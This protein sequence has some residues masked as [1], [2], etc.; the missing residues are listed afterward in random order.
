LKKIT[1]LAV[2][3]C[4]WGVFYSCQYS[5]LRYDYCIQIC[6]SLNILGLAL[7]SNWLDMHATARYHLYCLPVLHCMLEVSNP[8]SYCFK[9]VSSYFQGMEG[10]RCCSAGSS[11]EARNGAVWETK[12]R[13]RRPGGKHNNIKMRASNVQILTWFL[14]FRLR[15]EYFLLLSLGMPSSVAHFFLEFVFLFVL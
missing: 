13:T 7:T 6:V 10:R 2:R 3:K 5:Q 15:F 14:R 1:Q 4:S 8:I 12:P 11:A 9:H